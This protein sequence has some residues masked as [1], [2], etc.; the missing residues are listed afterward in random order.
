MYILSFHIFYLKY[1]ITD[2]SWKFNIAINKLKLRMKLLYFRLPRR[3]SR[4]LRYSWL[5]DN[6]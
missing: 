1:T 6:E 4:E 2:I 3:S 5:L